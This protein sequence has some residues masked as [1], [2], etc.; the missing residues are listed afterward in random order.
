LSRCPPNV[1][2]RNIG[3][4]DL[5]RGFA[6]MTKAMFFPIIPAPTTRTFL[7]FSYKIQL[8]QYPPWRHS[9]PPVR[10][11]DAEKNEKC[12]QSNEVLHLAQSPDG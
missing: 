9:C 11:S 2:F 6:V 5:E 7:M 10:K 3:Y 1:N 8:A 4:N 12:S